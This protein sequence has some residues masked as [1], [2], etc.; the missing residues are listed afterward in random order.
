MKQYCLIFKPLSSITQI[1]DAQT[2]FGAICNILL[3]TQGE[4]AFHQYIDSFSNDPILIHSSMFPKD[5]L[6]MIHQ[7]LFSTQYINEHLLNEPVDQQLQ[8]LQNMKKYKKV[9]Y[10]SKQIY[11]DYIQHNQFEQ[12]QNDIIHSKIKLDDLC[13]QYCDENIHYESS[14]EMTTHV[15]KAG[16]YMVDINDDKKNELFYDEQIYFKEGTQFCIYVKTTLTQQQLHDIFKYSHYFG[17]GNKHTVGKNSF[18]LVDIKEENNSSSNLKLLLSKSTLDKDYN[19][20]DSYYHIQSRIHRISNYYINDGITGRY[21]LFDEGSY[22]SVK[23][24][25]EWYGNI[26][27]NQDQDI[28]YYGIGYVF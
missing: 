6:P 4:E 22:M 8:Y 26:I 23:D 21:N 20:D 28:Y 7:S 9:P 19:L 10:M 25:K 5:M 24:N 13:L 27:Y 11:D 1:P 15:K 12:L 17:F 16:Y 2:L 18:E 14:T 3:Q